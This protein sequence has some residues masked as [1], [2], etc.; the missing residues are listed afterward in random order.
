MQVCI[1]QA[2]I[3]CE[4]QCIKCIPNTFSFQANPVLFSRIKFFYMQNYVESLPFLDNSYHKTCLSWII[5]ITK[6]CLSWKIPTSQTHAFIG[7][8]CFSALFEL[9][10]SRRKTLSLS[11]QNLITH[12]EKCFDFREKIYTVLQ[13]G[14]FS[15]GVFQMYGDK[16]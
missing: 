7:Q 11:L 8:V 12:L 16:T 10:K 5:S 1:V 2:P 9:Q 6:L 14:T 13:L 3:L 4:D 15:N